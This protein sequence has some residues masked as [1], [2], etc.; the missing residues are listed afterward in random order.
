[1]SQT[2]LRTTVARGVALTAALLAQL[3]AALMIISHAGFHLG[4]PGTPDTGR[5]VLPAVIGF[6]VA[7]LAYATIVLG[8]LCHARWAP[9]A[10]V[11]VFT[12]TLAAAWFPFRG[13]VSA[14]AGIVSIVA[15][16]ALVR[17]GAFRGL[18]ALMRR[19]VQRRPT[20]LR[21]IS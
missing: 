16:A 18:R 15:I 6:T 10:G 17:L 9:S 12:L 2:T 19:V 3:G 8:V 14:V 21:E 4:L 13:W 5:I 1:M 7:K 20:R 11:V